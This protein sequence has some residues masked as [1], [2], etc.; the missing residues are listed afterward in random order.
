MKAFLL[1]ELL[2]LVNILGQERLNEQKHCLLILAD[3]GNEPDEVQQMR[4]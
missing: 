3:M 2:G 4:L 1:V